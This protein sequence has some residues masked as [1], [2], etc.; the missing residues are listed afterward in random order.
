MAADRFE[1]HALTRPNER[2]PAGLI[3]MRVWMG[4][5]QAVIWSAPNREWRYNPRV[6]APWIFD[7]RYAER[8]RPVPRMEAERIA[9]EQLGT[10]LP[11][12][13]DLL[14]MCEAGAQGQTQG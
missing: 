14:A 7:D 9:R 5:L 11:S 10:E 8:Q 12:E 1:Y 3:A 2:V 13:R 6:A 4:P